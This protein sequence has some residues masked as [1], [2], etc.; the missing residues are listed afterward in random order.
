MI[1]PELCRWVTRMAV[2]LCLVG[3]CQ[4][5]AS[6][7]WDMCYSKVIALWPH[8]SLL[9]L[10]HLAWPCSA[11]V[12]CKWGW[13]FVLQYAHFSVLNKS[14][15]LTN[16]LPLF[17]LACRAVASFLMLVE[18]FNDNYLHAN[19]GVCVSPALCGSKPLKFWKNENCDVELQPSFYFPL[20]C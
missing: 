17:R 14:F 20:V 15:K 10:A 16:S 4:C 11:I 9:N 6:V 19:M 7:S 3:C 18:V 1:W 13:V 12:V 5:Y 8:I 2:P